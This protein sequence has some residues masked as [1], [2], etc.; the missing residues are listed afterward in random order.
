MPSA[1]TL[2]I[3]DAVAWLLVYGGLILAVL[4]LAT[5]GA[6]LL[7]GW[8]FGVVGSVAAIAG[9]VV[10]VVRARMSAAGGAQSAETPRRGAP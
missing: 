5:G 10:I 2:A 8:S 9:V 1:R 4:G 7:A 6:S 3:L